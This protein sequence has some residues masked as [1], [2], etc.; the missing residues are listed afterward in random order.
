VVRAFG[1]AD[2]AAAD[3]VVVAAYS[4]PSSRRAELARYL[5]LQPDGW[6]LVW[7][8]GQPVGVGGAVDYGPCAYVG[9]VG[10][11]P[12]M[13]RRGIAL[14]LMRHLLN[15]L[16]DRGCPTTL[17]DASA[18]GAPLYERL[19]FVDDDEALFFVRATDG[20][21]DAGAPHRP[22][23]P[24]TA[25]DLPEVVAFDAPI[26][27]APRTA[28]LASYLASYPGR[29]YVTRDA[30]GQL[31][32]Y[33][34]AQ[35]TLIGPWA[36]R[37]PTGA[38]ALLRAALTLSYG[39]GSSPRDGWPAAIVPASNRPAAALLSRYGFRQQRSLRHM[40][41]GTPPALQRAALLYG[42]VSFAVG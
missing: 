15:W 30:A 22:C 20:L 38:E 8:D 12:A 6:F 28:L 26:Y 18:A 31:T 2:L 41:R 37:T 25:A 36:A 27:G 29:A 13:R 19:G 7:V 21:P 42:Q 32:G 14:A 5:A 4:M 16:D 39:A 33:L 23:E 11:L 3:G 9:L 10:V 1:E 34:I 35:S 40:R 17:L 24:L